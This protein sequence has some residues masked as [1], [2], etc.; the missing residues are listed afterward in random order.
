[1]GVYFRILGKSLFVFLVLIGFVFGLFIGG[2]FGVYAFDTSFDL[3]GSYD[4]VSEEQIKVFDD[5]LVVDFDGE[6]LK[7]SKFDDSNSMHPFLNEN[8]NG[9][10]F[11]PDNP[12]EI[13]VGDVIS[14]EYKGEIF[15][16]RV[17]EI[18]T[19]NGVYS[20][21][22]KGDNND[23]VDPSVRKFEDINGVLIGVIF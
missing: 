5:Y 23:Y 6:E 3:G 9:L 2:F 20:F 13:H 14:F 19:K 10:E 7:W 15:V 18:N 22:T 1:M 4:H 12:E 16:H 8:Y 21:V 11:V 17:V